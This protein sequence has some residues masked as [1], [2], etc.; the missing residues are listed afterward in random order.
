MEESVECI[1]DFL[2]LLMN[3]KIIVIFSNEIFEIMIFKYE[4]NKFN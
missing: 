2:F 3:K 1:I 4:I